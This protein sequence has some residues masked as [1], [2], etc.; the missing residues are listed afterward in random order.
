MRLTDIIKQPTKF[1]N[2]VVEAAKTEVKEQ[3]KEAVTPSPASEKPAKPDA[4]QIEL[5][6]EINANMYAAIIETP[7][8]VYNSVNYRLSRKKAKNTILDTTALTAELKSLDSF[9]KE[10][11]EFIE[12]T[13]E[14]FGRFKKIA[15]LKAQKDGG[16]VNENLDMF[17][18]IMAMIA[19][20]A[21][22]FVK[23]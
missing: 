20:R 3:A 21:V 10:N 11:K 5:A 12:I 17:T 16:K 8:T 23:D 18:A 15:L 4:T 2:P 9:Y 13:D 22:I 14:E 7:L 1:I 6:A 19:K